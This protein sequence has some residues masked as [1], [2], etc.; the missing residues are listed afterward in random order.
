M[1]KAAV[2]KNT[3]DGDMQRLLAQAEQQ[4]RDAALAEARRQAKL[5][6]QAQAAALI[7]QQQ[8]LTRAAEAAKRKA[9]RET[10]ARSEAAKRAQEQQRQAAHD[11]LMAQGRSALAQQNVPQAIQYFQSAVAIRP[12]SDGDQALAEARAVAARSA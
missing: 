3:N 12:G 8:Q 6:S 1:T 9:I 4:A 5:Q 2:I 10:A 7:R 11:R